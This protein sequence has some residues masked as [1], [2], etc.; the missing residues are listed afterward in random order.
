MPARSLYLK[1]IFI[2]YNI[3]LSK[4]LSFRILWILFHCLLALY[5]GEV[6]EVKGEEKENKNEKRR[7]N[8]FKI[9]LGPFLFVCLFKVGLA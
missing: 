7:R 2:G 9:K 4:F 1:D 3:L 8:T 5:I 6:G